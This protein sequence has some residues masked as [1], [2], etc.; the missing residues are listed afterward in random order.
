MTNINKQDRLLTLI[1]A[2]TGSPFLEQALEIAQFD[3]GIY[4]VVEPFL[5][6][7]GNR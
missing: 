7:G 5:P 4:E 6:V 1:N 2:F 3:L